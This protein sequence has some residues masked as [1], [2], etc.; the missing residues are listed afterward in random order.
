[1]TDS[2]D[3]SVYGPNGFFRAFKGSIAA[4]KRR[5]RF[6]IRASY[7]TD[8]KGRIK[9]KLVNTGEH[10]AKLTVLD[11]YSGTSRSELL[12]PREDTDREWSLD[13]THGWY[14]LV[15]RVQDDDAFEYRLAGHVETGRD[16]MSDPALGGHVLKA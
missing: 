9:L 10:T 8:E 15:L 12:A 14:D 1:V 11:A 13:A 5:S 4:D 7:D 2:Y 3:L 16:S 6:D